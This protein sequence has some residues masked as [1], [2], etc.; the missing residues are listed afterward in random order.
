MMGSPTTKEAL[1]I[2]NILNDF[3]EV[4]NTSVNTK[5]SQ[6]FFFNTPLVFQHHITSLLGFSRSSLPSKY[7]GI[8][9]IDN[10]FCNSSW[11]SLT[12]YLTSCLSSWTFY[13]LNLVGRLVLL[14]SMLQA[15]H[16]YLFLALAAPK[17]VLKSIHNIQRQFL[18]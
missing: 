5:K 6:F 14:K 3:S 8:P 9:L 10:T 18:W 2:Y 16:V 17:V 12:N 1:K 13:S 4:S 7:L 15:I 11:E